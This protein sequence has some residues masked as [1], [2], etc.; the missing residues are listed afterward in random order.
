MSLGL[1]EAIRRAIPYRIRRSIRALLN[2]RPPSSAT[3]AEIQARQLADILRREHGIIPAPPKALQ[4]RVVGG[5]SPDFIESGWQTFHIFEQALAGAGREIRSFETV[6][7][8]G[9]GCGRVIRAFHQ[10]SP[11]ARLYGTDIDGEAIDWLAGNYQSF[12]HFSLNGH[13]PPFAFGDGSF[14]L[15]YGIS[16]FT[17]LSETMQ[18]AWLAE[19][20]RVCKLGAFLLL[21]IYDENRYSIL[22]ASNRAKFLNTGFCYV[23]EKVPTTE[24]LPVFY[25]TAFHSHEYVRRAWGRYFEVLTIKPLAV[26]GQDLVILRHRYGLVAGCS[27]TL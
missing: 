17:H 13:L 19:L 10:M 23:E 8:F 6:L 22:N 9:C 7:D 25:Q 12:A 1:S 24:G 20:Q 3:D 16:V 26:D 11:Q 5:Y 18:D 15:I 14:D 4:V 27:T 2:G 21:T